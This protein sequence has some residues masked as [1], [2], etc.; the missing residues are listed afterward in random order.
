[1][2][3]TEQKHLNNLKT[4][5]ATLRGLLLGQTSPQMAQIVCTALDE[6]IAKAEGVGM[7]DAKDV[8]P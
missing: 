6:Y 2:T 5:C 7:T 4:A 1:M 8:Q 3:T